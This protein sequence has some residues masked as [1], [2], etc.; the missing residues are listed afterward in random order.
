MIAWLLSFVWERFEYF[1]NK[2]EI[3]GRINSYIGNLEANTTINFPRISVKFTARDEKEEIILDD[4]NAILVIRD[5][6]HRSKNFIH[7]VYFFTSEM[8]LRKSKRHLSKH[9][10]TS[11]DIF[12]TKNILEKIN[13]SAA[14][15]FI[16][17]YFAPNFEKSEDIRKYIKQFY[18]ILIWLVCFSR[19]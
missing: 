9:Q 14:E 19:F 18:R 8:M 16:N 6:N 4:C 15:Q 3:E 12:A 11:L 1:S 10:K 5:R 2:N 13:K 17:D 7:S